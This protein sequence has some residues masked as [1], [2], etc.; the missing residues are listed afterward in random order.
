MKS[1][2]Y[3]LR[4]ELARPVVKRGMR[5]FKKKKLKMKLNKLMRIL[6]MTMKIIMK[7]LKGL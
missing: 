5:S 6:K 7:I 4:V 3:S 2:R 1:K